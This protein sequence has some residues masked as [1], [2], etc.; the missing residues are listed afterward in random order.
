MSDYLRSPRYYW[1]SDT[2]STELPLAWREVIVA[3]IW[4]GL[5]FEQIAR[6]VGCSLT[7]AYRRYHDGLAEM[8]ERVEGPC[9]RNPMTPNAS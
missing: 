7:S 1:K 5:T 3:R 8:K 4:G 9:R 2:L 6:L